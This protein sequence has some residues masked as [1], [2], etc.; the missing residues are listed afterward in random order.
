[1]SGHAETHPRH[2]RI[3][4][5]L[6]SDGEVAV[7]QLSERFSVTPMT[8][9]RDL[10]ALEKQGRLTRTHG[11]AVFTQQA[12]IEFAFHERGRV[13][14]AEKQAIAREA[15]K[16][17]EPG[18]TLVLDT[19]TT[20]LEVARALIGIPDLTVLTSS[21]AIASAL[22]AHE[23]IDLVLLGGNVN[24]RSPDLTGLLTEENLERFRVQLAFVGA[25]G[26]DASG[27][28]TTD[29]AI[30][31]VTRAMIN[32]AHRA[33]L[34]TDSSKFARTSFVRYATWDKFNHVITDRQL[35]VTNS[36]WLCKTNA[37][38]RFVGEQKEEK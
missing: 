38:V 9:R 33:V 26:A 24:R 30:A 19:G 6:A 23:K 22:H 25:D 28:F 18:M 29:M 37:D 14:Q 8:I 15:A 31:R 12:I 21:L 27:V 17:V 20:T 3:L 4:E 32:C 2:R 13:R 35:P 16:L 10:E 1:M 36:R 11:G 5:I 34:V 7:Q